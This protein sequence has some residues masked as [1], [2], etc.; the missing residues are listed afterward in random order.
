MMSRVGPGAA[1]TDG[2]DFK[3]R[4]KVATQYQ[5][6]ALLKSELRKLN[7]VHLLL[8]L[9]VAA[10]VTVS[11]LDL[12]PSDTVAEPYRWDRLSLPKNNISYLV[13]S[14]ISSGLF[15]IASLFYS[16]RSLLRPSSFTAKARPTAS[17]SA[18]RQSPSLVAVQVHAWQI[19]YSKKLLNAWFDFTQDKKKK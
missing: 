7:F 13:I 15:S 6:S 2:S 1:G 14:M 16:G 4:E 12:V 17:S 18:E 19:Y 10:Q 3:H 5:M 9:M 11:K 8:W